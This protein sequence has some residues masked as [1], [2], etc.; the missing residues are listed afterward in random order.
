MRPSTTTSTGR[1]LIVEPDAAL[2]G[3][4]AGLIDTHC[5]GMRVDMCQNEQ[6]SLIADNAGGADIAI[7][8]C[9]PNSA[10]CMDTL[11]QLLTLRACLCVLVLIPADRPE[12]ADVAIRAGAADVLLR[13]PGYLD[14]IAVC[15][16]KNVALARASTAARLRT[17]SLQR[18]IRELNSHIAE[19]RTEVIE[20]AASA[21]ETNAELPA[22]IHIAR[23]LSPARAA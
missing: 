6:T 1:V 7:A 12:L 11:R 17:E 8:S 10:T 21:R 20:T 9:G 14:Q 4:Y 2:A 16:R 19:L 15:V 22:T 23:P 13:A 5:P 18:T 3:L